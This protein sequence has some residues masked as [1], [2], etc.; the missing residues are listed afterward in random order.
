[1]TNVSCFGS[2]PHLVTLA[3]IWLQI[4]ASWHIFDSSFQ[5]EKIFLSMRSLFLSNFTI[6]AIFTKV[7]KCWFFWQSCKLCSPLLLLNSLKKW[8]TQYQLGQFSDIGKG[9]KCPQKQEHFWKVKCKSKFLNQYNFFQMIFSWFPMNEMENK[10][11]VVGW[12]WHSR[13]LESIST[14]ALIFNGWTWLLAIGHVLCQLWVKT[15]SSRSWLPELIHTTTLLLV[16]Y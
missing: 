8:P 3:T 10:H 6:K 12:L 16:A 7:K 13:S 14:A 4:W 2:C 5:Y 9:L 11:M 1:M 15:I